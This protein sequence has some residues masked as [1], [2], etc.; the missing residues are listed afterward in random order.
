MAGGVAP[1]VGGRR[2]GLGPDVAEP[3]VAGC[4][5]GPG[6]GAPGAP[7]RS[8]LGAP[9]PTGRTVPGVG[10][11]MG[12]GPP[13]CPGC[14]TGRIMAGCCG[15]PGRATGC[16]PGTPGRG[17]APP[18]C[19]P[20]GCWTAPGTGPA[21]RGCWGGAWPGGL[22]GCPGGPRAPGALL[23]DVVLPAGE[24]GVLT[25]AP[26]AGDAT[27]GTM[28]PTGRPGPATGLA[29]GCGRPWTWG[30]LPGPRFR[31]L[32]AR[33][34]GSAPCGAPY[35]AEGWPAGAAPGTP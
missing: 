33:P 22:A 35:W 20:A 21:N 24:A 4:G 31:R 29:P 19:G 25:G 13:A 5:A 12:R 9:G 8:G 34:L 30:P 17:P 28:G 27:P 3:G 26:P 7:G 15:T 18:G 10:P 16:G 32:N 14:C 6:P 11:A 1:I 2:S 23:D